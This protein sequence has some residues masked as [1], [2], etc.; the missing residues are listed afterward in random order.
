AK[1]DVS[2]FL[3]ML[4]EVVNLARQKAEV[5]ADDNTPPYDALLQDYEP[6]G[7]S[8]E[9]TEIFDNLRPHLLELRTEVLERNQPVSL[10]GHFPM[11]HRPCG[12]CI[13]V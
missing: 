1:D 13:W 3:P 7:S 12:Q 5:L 2:I 10:S 9:I 8:A 6:D 4:S 11:E